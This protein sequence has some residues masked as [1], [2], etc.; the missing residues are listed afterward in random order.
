M[1]EEKR[2]VVIFIAI[3]MLIMFVYP[4]F[5]GNH[6]NNAG[7]FQVAQVASNDIFSG[8]TLRAVERKVIATSADQEKPRDI[9]LDSKNLKGVISTLGIK[10][11]N[12]LL[13]KYN[14]D[15]SSEKVSVFGEKKDRYYARVEWKSENVNI[16]LPN[17]DT[18]W[19]TD[20]TKLS[21]KSPVT[22]TWDNHDGLLFERKISVDENFMISIV[23]KVKNYGEQ[24]VSLISTTGINREFDKSSNNTWT[25]YEGPLGYL[26]GKLEEFSYEDIVKKGE[27]KNQTNAGWFGITDKYW[28]VAFIPDQKASNNVSY[29]HFAE[30][31]KNIYKIESSGEPLILKPSSEF[32]CS[33]NLFVGAKEIKIL[34]MYEQKLGVKHFDLALDFGWF[35]IITK[36]LLYSLAF[37]KDIVGNMGAGILLLTLLIKLLLLPLANK[38]YHSMNRMKDIQPK[39]QELQKKYANDKVKLGQ[40]VS[41][42]YR[43][44]GVSPLG[45][46]LPTLLQSPVLFALYKVLY[47][48]IEMRQ[49]PFVL[50]IHDLSA[51]D[52][53]A[54]FNLFGLLPFAL[55]SF[56]QIGIWPI[57][58]G[59]SMFW[60]Q[61][62]GP[63]PS[64]PA[65]ANMMLI[66]PIMFTVMFAQLPS[67]LVIY[68]TFSNILAIAQQYFLTK[69]ERK[70]KA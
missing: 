18:I 19:K 33:Y 22:L 59:L 51:P 57:L 68:W 21:E 36:P 50:W 64:D 52:P 20:C 40:E 4:N 29:R 69:H 35:Y 42:I 14:K 15:K 37:L 54:I 62:I 43:K 23:D 10:I 66:M 47:I 2:N 16:L 53:L 67:G 41:A 70:K 63:T 45:G 46:C 44:E 1:E 38:S 26:N 28:L 13:K 11:D 60:Q 3:F 7:N 58:M 25:S 31:N 9:L 34:D 55:P 56:L 30:G 39:I 5:F 12:V 61:K 32:T 24:T 8:P 65:Q 49:A 6:Q 48:S 27:I 17:E